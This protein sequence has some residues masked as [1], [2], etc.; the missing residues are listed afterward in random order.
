MFK[1]TMA[2]MLAAVMLLQPVMA[3]AVTWGAVVGTINALREN[4]VEFDYV[5][6]DGVTSKTKVTVTGG[7]VK[8][9]NGT[10]TDVHIDDGTAGDYTFINVE[11]DGEEFV[12][13]MDT[14]SASVNLTGGTKVNVGETRVGAVAENGSVTLTVEKGSSI[15]AE[16][17]VRVYAENTGEVNVNNAGV[18]SGE[19]VRMDIAG[20]SMNVTN[21][22]GAELKAEDAEGEVS[23]WAKDGAGTF[24]NAGG[25]SGQ[26]VSFRSEEGGDLKVYNNF[27]EGD[28]KATIT[29]GDQLYIAASS[30]NEETR[31]FGDHSSIQFE[32]NGMIDPGR[33]TYVVALGDA[34][35]EFNNGENGVVKNEVYSE[36]G[37]SD[38]SSDDEAYLEAGS[39]VTE[40]MQA[41][42]KIT[43]TGKITDYLATNSWNQ[44][45]MDIENAGTVVGDIFGSAAD[46]SNL[47]MTITD[48]GTAG[49]VWVESFDESTVTAT[50]NGVVEN[51]Y[52][53]GVFGSGTVNLENNNQA[54]SSWV[55]AYGGGSI[56]MQNNDTIEGNIG[57]STDGETELNLTQGENAT[58]GEVGEIYIETGSNEV[59]SSEKIAKITENLNLGSESIIHTV[60]DEGQITAVYEV[61]EAGEIE[62]VESF[63]KVEEEYTDNT[64]SPEMI[65]HWM[66]ELRQEQAIGGVYGSPYWLKQLYLGYHSLNLRLFINGERELFREMLSWYNGG[67]EKR[68]TLRVNEENPQDLTMRLDGEVIDILERCEFAVIT[69]QDKNKNVVMEYNVADLKAARALYGLARTDL[70]CVGGPDS[71]VMKIGAD[72]QMVPVEQTAEK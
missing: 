54:G 71:E 49:H 60:N 6:E 48:K 19:H 7:K 72:G 21:Q 52:G 27:V 64:P 2:I 39:K 29:V 15:E 66:E 50:N 4:G 62:L 70:L 59:P 1:K 34:Q 63:V 38:Y 37:Y 22:I 8:F 31:E 14:G 51:E 57:I 36:A 26:Y 41:S 40:D 33:N 25:V 69:L 61:N 42:I 46:N 43:N 44:G 32:N 12:V 16:G 10:I 58:G 45:A 3:S 30:Y 20:G 28:E 53:G 17:P 67:P 23:M 65:R 47:N 24:N 13:H 68:L 5:V 11:V 35:T 55:S 9:E 18:I 56:T